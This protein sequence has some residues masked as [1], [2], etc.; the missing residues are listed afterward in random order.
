MVLLL[1]EFQHICK[2]VY[3]SQIINISNPPFSLLIQELLFNVQYPGKNV[4]LFCKNCR[5]L[6][7]SAF[8]LPNV[9]YL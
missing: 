4:F 1:N 9:F 6:L 3:K 7:T 8:L 2:Y 5:F